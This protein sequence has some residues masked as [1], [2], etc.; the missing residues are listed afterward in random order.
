MGV[1][2]KI[3]EIEL[4][5]RGGRHGPLCIHPSKSVLYQNEDTFVRKKRTSSLND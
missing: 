3:K 1:L 4:E 5:V 2:E